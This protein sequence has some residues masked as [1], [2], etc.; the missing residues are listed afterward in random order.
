MNKTPFHL[1]GS[2]VILGTEN[3]Q[4]DWTKDA[5][6][7]LITQEI[8]GVWGAVSQGSWMETKYK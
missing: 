6:I 4:T 1:G 2:E 8:P 5:P 7:A 3:K